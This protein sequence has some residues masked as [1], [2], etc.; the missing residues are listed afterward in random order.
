MC[1]CGKGKITA[2]GHAAGVLEMVPERDVAW[3]DNGILPVHVFERTSVKPKSGDC[4]LVGLPTGEVAATVIAVTGR[5]FATDPRVEIAL[6][7]MFEAGESGSPVVTSD[8]R[9]LAVVRNICGRCG[10]LDPL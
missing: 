9:L 5:D 6:D 10:T 8:N 3:L 1:T 7:R 4:V 2:D